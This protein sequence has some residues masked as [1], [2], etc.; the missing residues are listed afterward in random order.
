MS[1][2]FRKGIKKVERMKTYTKIVSVALGI[3]SMLL[4]GITAINVLYRESCQLF[5]YDIKNRFADNKMYLAASFIW[6]LLIILG[7]GL[8]WRCIFGRIYVSW[9]IKI[10]NKT[11]LVVL[12]KDNIENIK[13]DWKMDLKIVLNV[14]CA[15]AI[16]LCIYVNNHTFFA[17]IPQ[18]TWEPVKTIGHSFGAV[19]GDDYTGSLEAFEYNYALGRRTME[20]DLL[21]TADNR[22]VLKHDWDDSEQEGIS[23]NASLTEKEFLV[24][25]ILDKYTP[26]SFAGLCEMM[27]EYPDLWIVTDTKSTEIEEIKKQFEVLV[28]TAWQTGGEEIL[29][30]IIVQ[31]YNEEMYEV[32]NSIY[33]FKNY[34]FTMYLRFDHEDW[35][36]IMRDVCRFCVNNGIETV[37]IGTNRISQELTAIAGHYGRNVYVHTVNDPEAAD[38][39]FEIGVTGIY[40]DIIEEK[41]L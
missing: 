34:I 21:L 22:L 27:L 29:D 38:R 2:L 15:A 7:G 30:R 33:R 5:V 11:L 37:T 32:V 31:V 39:Y 4:I 24:T 18:G 20:V 8:Y 41:D 26:L 25:K 9:T 13:A 10:K 1:V 12:N 35:Q 19:N 17:S 23:E 3:L 40:T 28:D 36:G 16:V 14:V 6:L